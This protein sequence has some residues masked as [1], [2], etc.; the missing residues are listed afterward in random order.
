MFDL[1]WMELLFVAVLALIVVGP[2]DLPKLLKS[3]SEGMRKFRKLYSDFQSGMHKLEK[4]VDLVSRDGDSTRNWQDYLPEGVKRLPDDFLPG[5]TNPEEYQA[6][7]ENYK[8]EV[9]KAKA[10]FEI[11]NKNEPDV[12]HAGVDKNDG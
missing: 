6:I 3:F 4:E 10:Q 7:R 1:S 5:Q 11:D 2:K 12:K 9:N 8:K